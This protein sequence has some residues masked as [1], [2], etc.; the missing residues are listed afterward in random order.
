MKAHSVVTLEGTVT[1]DK[2]QYCSGIWFDSGEAEILKKD[3]MSEFLDSGNLKS[4]KYYNEI[5]DIN[6]PRCNKKMTVKQD[7]EQPHI[8]YETCDEHG[9]FMD[10]GEFTDY[11]HET[12]VDF[13]MKM[14][15]R[16]ID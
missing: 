3:W 11:K 7:P 4:G 12:L 8:R 14:I 5:D 2:C 13:F 1:I 16:L 10:A 6:C 15:R 9:V